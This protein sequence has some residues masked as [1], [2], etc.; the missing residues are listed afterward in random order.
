MSLADVLIKLVGR[1]PK[2]ARYRRL[3]FDIGHGKPT[4]V[5]ITVAI[6]AQGTH[7][8]VASLQAYLC[9]GSIP[10]L[11]CFFAHEVLPGPNAPQRTPGIEHTNSAIAQKGGGDKSLPQIHLHMPP[12]RAPTSGHDQFS[13]ALQHLGDAAQS[14]SPL[15]PWAQVGRVSEGKVCV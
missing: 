2:S 11:V 9:M 5:N 3:V 8:A 13:P 6:L 4:K 12:T 10:T 7:W 14:S 15:S 1:L